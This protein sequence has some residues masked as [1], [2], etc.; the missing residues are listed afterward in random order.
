MPYFSVFFVFFSSKKTFSKYQFLS[1]PR[2]DR[3]RVSERDEQNS[4][5]IHLSRYGG[6]NGIESSKSKQ[7]EPQAAGLA[8]LSTLQQTCIKLG[9][10]SYRLGEVQQ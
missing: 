4:T 6:A 3:Q 1:P 2:A 9:V 7:A 5:V 10:N 8:S